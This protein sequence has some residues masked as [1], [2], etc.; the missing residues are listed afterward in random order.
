M[1]FGDL[2]NAGEKARVIFFDNLS[3]IDEATSDCLCRISTGGGYATR[4]LYTNSDEVIF[5]TCNPV[6]VASMAR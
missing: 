6:V 1:G 2:F 4:K 5:N 3:R